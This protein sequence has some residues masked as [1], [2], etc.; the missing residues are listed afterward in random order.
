MVH[1]TVRRWVPFPARH[2]LTCTAAGSVS[3]PV[4]VIAFF[5]ISGAEDLI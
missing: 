2:R 4:L 3:P 5:T 1:P